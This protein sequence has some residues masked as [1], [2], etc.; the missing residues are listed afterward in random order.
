MEKVEIPEGIP[1]GYK[2]HTTRCGPGYGSFWTKTFGEDADD[3]VYSGCNVTHD[4]NTKDMAVEL[5]RVSVWRHHIKTRE[6]KLEQRVAELEAE[7]AVLRD[8]VS[9]VDASALHVSCEGW[10]TWNAAVELCRKKLQP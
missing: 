7:N 1:P 3:G 10:K 2:L 6:Y 8:T 5:A 9:M 4:A